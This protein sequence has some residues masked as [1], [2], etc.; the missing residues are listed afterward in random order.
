MRSIGFV[1]GAAAAKRRAF[2]PASLFASGEDG[3][4]FVVSPSHAFQDTVGGTPTGV[5]DPIG[6]LRDLSGNGNHWSQTDL[7]RRPI[8][9]EDSGKFYFQR[10]ADNF[11]T[12]TFGSAMSPTWERISAIRQQ[13]WASGNRVF[14]TTGSVTTGT[15]LQQSV[16]PFLRMLSGTGPSISTTLNQDF[17]V[18][19]RH[20]GA[21]SRI[22]L[23]NGSYVTDAMNTNATPGWRALASRSGFSQA[24]ARIYGAVMIDR[25]LTD[26]EISD[27]REFMADLIQKSI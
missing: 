1:V 7:A 2:S 5:G 6:A 4:F 20:A 15:L 19:E 26:P 21:S 18:T 22:A 16:E 17:V 9:R 12:L 14:G 13:S 10:D 3:A 25:A 24:D 27:T 11:I 8:L 23:D